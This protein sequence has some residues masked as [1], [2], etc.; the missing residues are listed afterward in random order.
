M[1]F[2]WSRWVWANPTAQQYRAGPG[3]LWIY[4]RPEGGIIAK[5]APFRLGREPAAPASIRAA[6]A[7]AGAESRAVPLKTNRTARW[8]AVGHNPKPV[9]LIAVVR[10]VVPVAVR[11]AHV[12]A[13]VVERPA[14]N[15]ARGFSQPPRH[16]SVPDGMSPQVLHFFS[17]PPTSGPAPPACGRHARIGPC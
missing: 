10:V 5:S 8:Q 4:A 13:I 17:S 16:P 12:V 6:Q 1:S 11:G 15:H 9:V 2:T 3:P 7:I 14:A